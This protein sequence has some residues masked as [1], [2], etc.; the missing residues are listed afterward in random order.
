[1]FRVK[2]YCE[3]CSNVQKDIE[4]T[5]IKCG[6]PYGG[7][8]WVLIAG[9]ILAFSIPLVILLSGQ[10]LSGLLSPAMI[11]AYFTPVI[12]GTAFLYDYHPQRRFFY[13]YGCV[14]IVAFWILNYVI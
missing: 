10:S 6:H 13:F 8:S 1:M 4:R 2:I 7:E 12:C 11:F 3:K 9:F 5:C 14:A